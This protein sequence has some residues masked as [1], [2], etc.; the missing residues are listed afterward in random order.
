MKIKLYIN[1]ENV[2]QL[3]ICSPHIKLG[4][5]L[6]SNVGKVMDQASFPCIMGRLG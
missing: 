6:S 3:S 1:N 2:K 5:Y 4:F